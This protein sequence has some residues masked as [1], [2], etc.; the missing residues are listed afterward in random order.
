MILWH[1]SSA[2]EEK[3]IIKIKGKEKRLRKYLCKDIQLKCFIDLS[4]RANNVNAIQ[5]AI[6]SQNIKEM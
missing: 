5:A 6:T 4:S 1:K 2:E 3:Y